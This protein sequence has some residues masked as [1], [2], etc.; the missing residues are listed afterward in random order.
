MW[1]EM[2][3]IRNRNRNLGKGRNLGLWESSKNEHVRDI[4]LRKLFT[5]GEVGMIKYF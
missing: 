3:H 2:F 1:L 5:V 4:R